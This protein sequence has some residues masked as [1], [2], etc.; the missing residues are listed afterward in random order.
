MRDIQKDFLD[1][2]DLKKDIWRMFR[3]MSDFTDSFEELDELPPSVSI[4]GSARVSPDDYYYKQAVKISKKLS[5]EGFGIITGGGGGIMEAGNK[6]ADISVGLNIALPHEQKTNKYVKTELKFKYFFTRKVVFLKY[7]VAT[8][9]MP[10]GFGTLDEL[11]EVLT[12]AQTGRMSKVPIVF[13]GTKFYKPLM[14]FFDVM[15]EHKYINK[16]DKNLFILTDDVNEAV[17]YITKNA[18]IP[19][20]KYV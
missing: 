13:F 5:K 7:S 4:F 19:H 10:G 17:D 15:I 1:N 8:I 16:N 9:M 18:Y 11:S 12:L 14:D 6:G 2:R 3:V 20:I